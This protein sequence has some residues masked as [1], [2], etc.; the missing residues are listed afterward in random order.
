MAELVKNPKVMKRATA[1]VR[2]AFEA[3]GKVVLADGQLHHPQTRK[4]S[5]NT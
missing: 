2:R 4:S 5:V 3:G 1:E